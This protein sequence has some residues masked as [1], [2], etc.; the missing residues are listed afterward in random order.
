MKKISITPGSWGSSGVLEL[1]IHIF[2]RKRVNA[3]TIFTPM[4][5]ENLSDEEA[6]LAKKKFEKLGQTVKEIAAN[7][8]I[9]PG[10]TGV[11][12]H[13]IDLFGIER[14]DVGTWTTPVLVKDLS[15]AEVVFAKEFFKECG[16]TVEVIK[17]QN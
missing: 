5:V 2:G 3:G 15:E 10:S 17:E 16:Q 1:A 11:A 7:I 12:I 13:A 8:V 14:V 4:Y 9:S 6:A